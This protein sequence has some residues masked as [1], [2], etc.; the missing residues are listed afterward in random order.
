[1][2]LLDPDYDERSLFS[3]TV[4]FPMAGA[5]DGGTSCAKT[6]EL[7]SM[8]P[9]SEF[10]GTVSLPFEAGEHR[11][12]AVKVVDDR[13]QSSRSRSSG[14][15]EGT[16]HDH[17]NSL[18]HQ[19]TYER[20]PSTGGRPR[21]L[22][23]RTGRRPAGYEIFDTPPEHPPPISRSAGHSIRERVDA[24]RAPSGPASPPSL[25]A[26]SSLHERAV[27]QLPFYF[28]HRG[29]RDADLV[30]R[31]PPDFKQGIAVPGDG[32]GWSGCAP[33]WPPARQDHPDAMI[34]TC[35]CSTPSPTQAQQGLLARGVHRGAGDHGQGAPP[36]AL[37]GNPAN[38]YDE[39]SLCP[40][41]AAR[42]CQV[43]RQH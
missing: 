34:I 1:V 16:H 3:P 12:V 43:L 29:H 26:C 6:S 4:F 17:P 23:S 27:R 42:E 9:L 21:S 15:N 14:W 5:K 20:P 39:F 25:A 8:R 38:S 10:H 36:G 11:K 2:W 7:S 13:G 19:L 22:V 40:S 33:R 28:C 18:H 35:R 32:G 31:R 37:P 41:R 24:W 30:G